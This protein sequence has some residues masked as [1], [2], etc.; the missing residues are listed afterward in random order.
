M[1]NVEGHGI[2]GNDTLTATARSL[3]ITLFGEAGDDTINGGGA[4]DALY[5][6]W[7]GPADPAYGPPGNDTINGNASADVLD[8]GE[9]NDLLNGGAGAAR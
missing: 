1:E 2:D 8:G 6:D 7:N 4:A 3:P 5:G 9:G